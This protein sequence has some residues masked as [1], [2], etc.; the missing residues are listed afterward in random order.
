VCA[1]AQRHATRFSTS[2]GTGKKRSVGFLSAI[3][4]FQFLRSATK[5]S[6]SADLAF[7]P[8][9]ASAES[10]RASRCAPAAW[11]REAELGDEGGLRAPRRAAGCRGLRRRP[12]SQ[13]SSAI[14][15]ASRAR[16]RNRRA[17]AIPL[18]RTGEECASMQPIANSA[19]VL[20]VQRGHSD[21]LRG[22]RTSLSTG[23][24]QHLG[25]RPAQCRGPRAAR[26]STGARWR[27]GEISSR[28]R[29]RRRA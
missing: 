7:A 18:R 14:W 10:A 16:G 21:R 28:G 9:I 19:R 26:A 27:P 29:Y 5:R 25:R 23:K 17:P 2:S 24:I 22:R 12:R 1:A 6:A 20:S 8:K 11:R 4:A 13:Q 15:N 3:G